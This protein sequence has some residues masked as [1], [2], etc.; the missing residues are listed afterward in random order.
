MG[1]SDQPLDAIVC[2]KSSRVLTELAV[3]RVESLRLRFWAMMVRQQALHVDVPIAGVA[4][5]WV[6]PSRAATRA[7]FGTSKV[8][9][10]RHT[11]G[12]SSGPPDF[13]LLDC[14]V[15]HYFVDG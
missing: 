14:V 8:D 3:M 15:G 9:F 7:S 11:I 13:G 5:N 4:L 10:G 12:G 2:E 1:M 6:M